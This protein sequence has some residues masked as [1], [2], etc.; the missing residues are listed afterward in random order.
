MLIDSIAFYI[1][2]IMLVYASLELF[3]VRAG[4]VAAPTLDMIARYYA[5]GTL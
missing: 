4:V 3:N 5:H 1:V 2:C